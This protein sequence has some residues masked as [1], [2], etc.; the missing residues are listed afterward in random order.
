MI[1][2]LPD[3]QLRQVNLDLGPRPQQIPAVSQVHTVRQLVPA[4]LTRETTGYNVVY[5]TS[6]LNDPII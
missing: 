1:A 6:V 3:E 2:L 4:L 5:F